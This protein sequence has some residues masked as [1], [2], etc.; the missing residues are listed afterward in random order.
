MLGSSERVGRVKNGCH[1]LLEYGSFIAGRPH[2]T[3]EAPV[4][5]PLVNGPHDHRGK[6]KNYPSPPPGTVLVAEHN[7]GG[8]DAILPAERVGAWHA[9]GLRRFYLVHRRSG[10]NED[11]HLTL[12]NDIL[13][14]FRIRYS[15][16]IELMEPGTEHGRLAKRKEPADGR[17]AALRKHAVSAVRYYSEYA[18]PMPLFRSR[19]RQRFTWLARRFNTNSTGQFYDAIQAIAVGQDPEP[20]LAAPGDANSLIIPAMSQHGMRVRLEQYVVSPR[21]RRFDDDGG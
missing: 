18:D 3:K 21:P 19:L 12:G 1:V 20:A 13:V 8:Y 7:H 2:R 17:D 5:V 15:F 16:Y 10:L 11:E 14:Q 6:A 9:R 4:P